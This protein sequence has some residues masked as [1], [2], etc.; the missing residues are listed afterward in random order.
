M[1]AVWLTSTPLNFLVNL[2]IGWN[3]LK[4]YQ[5]I[6]H[7]NVDSIAK[8][9]LPRASMA[10]W[11]EKKD[12]WQG[13]VV[14]LRYFLKLKAERDLTRPHVVHALLVT[15]GDVEFINDVMFAGHLDWCIPL[16][17]SV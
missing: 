8:K 12:D 10:Q 5:A 1:C 15:S 13:I 17:N 3:A 11:M 7:L 16:D 14:E 6:T 9:L 2:R 4:D